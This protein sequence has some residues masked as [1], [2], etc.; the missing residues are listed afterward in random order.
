MKR[1]QKVP[2]SRV[3]RGGM[4]TTQLSNVEEQKIHRDGVFGCQKSTLRQLWL[5]PVS[6]KNISVFGIGI[7]ILLLLFIQ[8][9]QTSSLQGRRIGRPLPRFVAVNETHLLEFKQLDLNMEV[10]PTLREI[11]QTDNEWRAKERLANSKEYKRGRAEPLET[12]DCKAQ[13]EWQK[14]SFPTCNLLFEFDLTDLGAHNG[15]R[16]QHIANG[17]WRDV[18]TVQE[19]FSQRRVLK[20]RRMQHEFIARNYDRHRRDAVCMERLTSS[21]VVMDIYGFCGNSGLFEFANG[22]SIT[23][24]IWPRNGHDNTLTPLQKLTIATHVA[25]GLAAVH[26]VEK[27]GQAAMAH[28]DITPDNTC[29][30]RKPMCTS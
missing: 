20:T 10:Y 29:S 24:A 11:S 9:V 16:V 6:Q 12:E 26:N 14:R 4:T 28:T 7:F 15:I 30:T 21:P 13:Y 3:S 27:E 25:M 8:T 18:F 19:A 22:G 17:Y 5:F 2:R 23:D 1:Q